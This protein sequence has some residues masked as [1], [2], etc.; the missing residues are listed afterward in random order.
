[1]QTRR[2][3]ISLAAALAGSATAAGSLIDAIARAAEIEPAAGSSVLDAEHVVI[4]MQENRSFDHAFGSLRGV[5]GFN[6]PRAITLPDGNPVW[7][8]TDSAGKQYAPFRYDINHTKITWMGCLPHGWADQTDARNGGR[9]DQWLRVKRSGTREYASLPLTL[10][11][12][13]RADI[14]FYYALADAFTICDQ[15]FCSSLTGTTPNRCYLWTG[16]IRERMSA[17]VP[18]HV[19]NEEAD[20]DHLVSWPTFPERLEALGVPWKVY[21]NELTVL[22]GL[23][24]AQD[25]WLANYGDNPLEYF[26]QYHVYLSPRHR[27]FVERRLREIPDEIAALRQQLGPLDAKTPKP[28]AAQLAKQIADLTLLQTQYKA[29]RDRGAGNSLEKLAPQERAIHER[30]FSVNEADPA[31]RELT[32][33]TY[34]S[35]GVARTMKIPKGDVLHQFRADVNGGKLPTVSW[36]VAP[37]AFSDH[38]SSAWYGA[39]YI[40]EVLNILTA[41]PEVWKK[42]VFLLTYDENDGYFDHVPPFVAPRAGHGETGRAS[43]GIDTSVDYVELEQDRRQSWGRGSRGHSIGLGYRVPMIIASPW[44][45][46]G[47][48][49]SQVFDH[50]SVLQ[51]LE[52][53]VTHKLGK[54]VVETN[55]TRWRRA[56]CG[57]LTSSFQAAAKAG[58]ATVPFATSREA[59]LESIHRAQFQPPPTDIKPLTA[60]DLAAIRATPEK[61]RLPRQEPGVR[62][63]CP[64]PYELYAAGSLDADRAKFTMRLEARN[65]AFGERAAGSPFIVYALSAKGA[66]AANS[67]ETRADQPS[68]DVAVRDYAVEAGKQVDDAW[69]L[70]DFAAGRYLLRAHGPNGF[71]RE[72]AGDAHDPALTCEFHYA[73]AAD[74]RS[75]NG[76]LE[77]V[78]LNRD[79]QQSFTVEV[80]DARLGWAEKFVV[81]PSQRATRAIETAQSAAWYDVA[82]RVPAAPRFLI[83]ACGRIETGKWSTSDPAMA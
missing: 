39:W 62:P 42:T 28:G 26:R 72:F 52:R 57:D 11:H 16:T 1:M 74:R 22:S 21:Q 4:L 7:V 13:T 5:R 66:H 12:Y 14:P 3:F 2:E 27:A 48:V 82:V 35:Q 75:P 53:F 10:G 41:R 47:C 58:D 77:I 64:L 19:R 79:A 34:E 44:S 20:L 29:D 60:A 76:V 59:F 31:Y 49:C 83:R 18:A 33:V 23:T 70:A 6:D 67:D 9:Y 51:F 36:I 63:S 50:T 78:L 61:S 46:G 25:N 56:V 32:E 17:D 30:A 40:A 15:Y 81:A 80:Q 54:S 45:R 55:I 65:E 68:F 69:K 8:Q 71:F 43:E 38:P 73:R 24:E 37:A